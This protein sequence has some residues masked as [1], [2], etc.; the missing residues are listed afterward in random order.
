MPRFI[1]RGVKPPLSQSLCSL[2]RNDH[3]GQLRL[4][5]MASYFFITLFSFTISSS[6][7]P[8]SFCKLSLPF[9]PPL[10]LHDVGG[11]VV[12]V[13]TLWWRE[14]SFAFVGKRTK[15]LN[16]PPH[17]SE[18]S[19]VSLPSYNQKVS[20]LDVCFRCLPH[21]TLNTLFIGT[22]VGNLATTAISSYYK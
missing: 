14:Q 10:E 15:I 11:R 4:S 16:R 19:C 5:Y 22:A 8:S 13:L 18:L 12:S 6:S 2:L 3:R 1:I 7:S 17:S 21:S 20:V 9:P